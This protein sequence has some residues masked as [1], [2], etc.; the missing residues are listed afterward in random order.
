MS[1]AVRAALNARRIRMCYLV[2]A[3]FATGE[4]L[5]AS[6]P[7][8]VRWGNKEWL[9]A[10][11]MLDIDFAK[12]DSTLE[13]HACRI[14]LDGMDAAAISQALNEPIE[15]TPVIIHVLTFDP[16]TN[17]PIGSYQFYRGTV[18]EIRIIPPSSSQ[19]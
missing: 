1:T 3:Q 19:E 14:T 11:R 15:N 7:Q 5:F 6:T 16:D 2:E 18:G 13:A 17:I 8:G 12:E 10:G 4:V 9:G